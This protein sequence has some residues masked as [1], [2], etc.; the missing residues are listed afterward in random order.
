MR[1]KLLLTPGPTPVPEDVLQAMAQPMMHHRHTEFRSILAEVKEQLKYLFQT[2]NDVLIFASTGTGAMEGAVSNT[3]SRGDK[4][5]VV[6]GGKFG[7]RWAE[8]CQTY[9]VQVIPLKVEWGKAVEP[10]RVEEALKQHP[11]VKAVFTQATETSTGVRHPIQE[12]AQLVASREQTLM[13]VDA[14]TGIGVFDIPMDNWHLDVV[15]TG[16]QKALMLPPGLAF[17]SL[18]EKAWRCAAQ[19]N[20]PKFYFDF[21]KERKNLAKNQGSYTSPVS[22]ILGLRV[23]L[24]KIQEEGLPRIF[25]RTERMARATRHAIEALGLE[26]FAPDSPSPCLTAVKVP[27]GVD[28]EKLVATIRDKHGVAIAGG[29]EPLKG[30]IFR[31]AHMGYIQEYDIITG[32]VALEATLRDLGYCSFT[33]GTSVQA[34]LSVLNG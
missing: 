25:E 31:I 24:R 9:G 18:S 5:L 19:S 2:T 14:I 1:K 11:D 10:A 13:I 16:S 4:A 6:I 7:E 15:V 28:G 12:L 32:L 23:A 34:A 30:K 3:L 22:L 29:Q 33:P 26:L 27:Q 20:L 21:A 8:L 17:V